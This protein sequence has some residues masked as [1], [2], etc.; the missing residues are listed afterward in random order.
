MAEITPTPAPQDAATTAPQ[1]ATPQ[2]PDQS[3]SAP[4][5]APAA[6]AQVNPADQMAQ[7]QRLE[8]QA[9]PTATPAAPA[10]TAQ[11]SPKIL[12]KRGLMSSVLMGALKGADEAMRATGKAAVTVAENTQ[13]GQRIRENNILMKKQQQD[14][15]IAAQKAKEEATKAIDDHTEALLRV[16]NAFLDNAH[17]AAENA[18]IESLYPLEEQ[19]ERLKLIGQVR[20]QNDADRQFLVTL[21][22]SGVHLDTSHFTK[23]GAFEQLTP[24]HAKA[25]ANGKQWGLSNGLTGDDADIAFVSN[26]ELANT[27][28]PHD[29][30]VVTDW[31]LNPTTGVMSPVYSTLAAGQNTA[32]DAVIAHDAGMK[33][34]N[35]KQDMYTKQV[36]AQQKA[37]QAQQ[38]RA[39]AELDQ[40][41]VA[42][43]K[44]MGIT[45]PVGYK[46]D[47]NNFTLD[48]SALQQ[49]L[50]SQGV[51]TPY[52]FATLYGIAHYDID[53]KTLTTTLRKGVGQMTRD[54]AMNYVRNFMN[55]NYDEKEYDALKNMEKEFADTRQGTSGGNLIA[56]NTA[57]G[58]LGQLYDAALAMNNNDL[59]A[60]NKIAN[61]LGVKTAGMS[62]PA[63]FD[64]VKGALVGELGRTFKGAAADIPERN[65]IEENLSRNNAPNVLMDL[66]KTY[67]H[68]ML[69]KAG[70]QVAHYY[71]F[72]GTLPAQTIDP[73]ARQVYQRL[74]INVS[75]ILPQG[76]TTPVGSTANPNPP[77]NQGQVPQGKVPVYSKS[78]GA[79][80]GYADDNKLTNYVPF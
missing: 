75:D 29:V 60:L 20:Q 73:L 18:H 11:A 46:P 54:G 69:T 7:A 61:D 30:Q 41:Q 15:Q 42:Q 14:Q 16:N 78:T 80:K 70:A 32:L 31:N 72:K 40:A 1:Q 38:E 25:V 5:A 48:Q 6:T 53:P 24:D 55:T 22:E 17:K 19:E 59:V 68:L 50:T 65:D 43:F 2:S 47:P 56:F 9:N 64:A 8:A 36:E 26:A 12:P 74:G 45:A 67:A 35:E 10:A 44:A 76:A 4:A 62:A 79:L 13:T 52:N 58:H 71:A 27:V 63:I 3:V 39:T 23:G 49:K 51:S 34:F 33:R 66:T 77:S 21:E 37:A 28:L 57:T